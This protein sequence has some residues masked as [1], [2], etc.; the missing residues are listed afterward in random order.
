MML[1]PHSLNYACGFAAG[2]FPKFAD[3]VYWLDT[4][5]GDDRDNSHFLLPTAETAL[6][7]LHR[8]EI[9]AESELPKSIL[10]I[11]LLSKRGR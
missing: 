5:P 2:Q 11:P 7:N 1:V 8:D 4:L 9:L 10:L 3:D 6:V